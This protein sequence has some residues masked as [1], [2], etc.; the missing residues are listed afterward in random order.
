[1]RSYP[2]NSPHAAARLVALAMMAD[3][4][5]SRSEIEVIRRL[6]IC[7]RLS[8]SDE[9]WH[10][11]VHELCT[12][13]LDTARGAMSGSCR[14]APDTLRDMLASVDDARLRLPVMQLCMA[15]VDADQ[16]LADGE[17]VVLKALI[18]HWGMGC[19]RPEHHEVL[20]A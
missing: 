4:N 8:I 18:E 14:I 13:L 3:G 19:E 5:V 1:M 10:N 2:R 6:D 17:A 16:Q 12:D 20:A 7:K 11:V 9:D 15:V